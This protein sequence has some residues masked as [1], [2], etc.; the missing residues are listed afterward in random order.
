VE[1]LPIFDGTPNADKLAGASDLHQWK[2]LLYLL[3]LSDAYIDKIRMML[4]TATQKLILVKVIHTLI[5]LF[6]NFVILYML[7]ASIVR[8]FDFW[9]LL[10]YS[11]VLL[12]GLILALY[13]F[14]CPLTLIAR[15]YT[16]DQKDNFDIFLP[17]WLARNTKRL[18][19][20]IVI[21]ILFITIF[22]YI[23][24]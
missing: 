3:S 17:V 1:N 7:Y 2:A 16:D 14:T 18:Y 23:K 22:Q 15:R 4:L 20:S 6:Y 21:I 11:L 9:L 10:C 24:S 5:W 19:T 8:K 13:R 12:E